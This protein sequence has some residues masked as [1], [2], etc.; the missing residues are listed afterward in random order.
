MSKLQHVLTSAYRKAKTRIR[1]EEKE[2]LQMHFL[3]VAQN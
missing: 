1:K 3:F 2:R